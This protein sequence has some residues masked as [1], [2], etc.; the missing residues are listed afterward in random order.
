LILSIRP[1]GEHEL[2]WHVATLGDWIADSGR[3]AP[4]GETR[5]SSLLALL[6]DR[7]SEMDEA[8]YRAIERAIG[9]H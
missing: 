5:R 4:L 9:R 6:E 8:A 3:Y 7:R 2:L 1:S